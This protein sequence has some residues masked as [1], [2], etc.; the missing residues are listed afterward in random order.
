MDIQLAERSFA[1]S[2][3]GRRSANQDAALIASLPDGQEL[4]AVADGMGGH[5]AGEVASSRA[6]EVLLSEVSAG[7][8]LVE[9]VRLANSVVFNEANTRPEYL[10]MGTTLVA[11]LRDGSR[12]H[13][14]NVGDSR[15]YRVDDRGVR[16]ITLDHSFSAEALRSGMAAEEV[17][18]SPWRNA[19]TRSVGTASEIEVDCFGPFDAAEEHTVLLCSDGLYR[20]ISEQDMVELSES[21][22][23]LSEAAKVLATRAFE[24]GSDDNITVALLRFG[25]AR[26]P[27]WK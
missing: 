3:C 12:Y 24:R 17:E 7:C 16:Q 20:T 19:L 18:K 8:D 13:V 25:S 11:L 14:A 6:L 15:A 2:E 21:A 23:S 10:G 4:I 1:V 9:A 27:G 22:R 26:I 5:S